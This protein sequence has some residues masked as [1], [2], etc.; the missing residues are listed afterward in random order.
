VGAGAARRESALSESAGFVNSVVAWRDAAIAAIV[1]S[2][3]CL[4]TVDLGGGQCIGDDE[5]LTHHTKQRGQYIDAPRPEIPDDASSC[6]NRQR[7]GHDL[8]GFSAIR[9][10]HGNVPKVSA[11]RPGRAVLELSIIV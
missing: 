10:D 4:P 8:P 6:G 5:M 2:Q 7:T 1:G 9:R 11:K 3:E